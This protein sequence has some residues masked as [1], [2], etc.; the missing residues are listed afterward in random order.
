MPLINETE[1]IKNNQIQKTKSS[2]KKYQST[3]DISQFIY[4]DYMI[5]SNIYSNKK[6]Q[7]QIDLKLIKFP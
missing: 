4:D 7:K 3:A 2:L 6:I 5:Q 1:S